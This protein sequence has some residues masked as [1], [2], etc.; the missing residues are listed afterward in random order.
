MNNARQYNQNFPNNG[1]P[2]LHLPI[3]QNIPMPN[4]VHI[5]DTLFKKNRGAMNMIFEE[6]KDSIIVALLIIAS[7]LPQIN[8]AFHK[9]LPITQNS[10]Y[11]LFV[12]K[13]VV[14][15]LFFWLIKHF[16]LSRKS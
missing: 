2:I 9:I 6:G 13:G 10:P 4:E 5:I 15:G 7:C 12:V 11:F 1:D 14:F 3:D 8:D 16:Y